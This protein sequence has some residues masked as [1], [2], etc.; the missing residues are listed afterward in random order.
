MF[1][2]MLLEGLWTILLEAFVDLV[3]HIQLL[4]IICAEEEELSYKVD[5]IS[6]PLR[7]NLLTRTRYL[8]CRTSDSIRA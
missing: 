6:D 1:S 4:I 8:T 3:F 2:V 5:G 7:S